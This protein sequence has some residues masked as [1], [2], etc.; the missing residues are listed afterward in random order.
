VLAER[1][2]PNK[3][4]LIIDDGLHLP[5]ANF[6]TLNALLPLLADDGIFV[7][8]DINTEHRDFWHIA[9]ASLCLPISNQA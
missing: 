6:N 5:H 1:L 3:F 9:I 8:E 7:V 2:R 4:E